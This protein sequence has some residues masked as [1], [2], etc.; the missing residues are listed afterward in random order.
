MNKKALAL[1]FSDDKNKRVL[2]IITDL[3]AEKSPSD[4][5]KQYGVARSYVYQIKD[6]Y[7]GEIK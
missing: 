2:D 4:I 3:L 5:A 6:K 1:Y 7:I